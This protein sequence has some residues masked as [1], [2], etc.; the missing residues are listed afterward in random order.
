[1]VNIILC[2]GSGTRLWPLSRSLMP[3]Q[4]LRI[5]D[6]KSLFLLTCERNS[7][8]CEKTIVVSNEQ[9]Y[10]LAL[11]EIS[12]T[13]EIYKNIS[14]LLEPLAKN[15]APAIALACMGLSAEEVV[16]ITPSDHLIKDLLA[17]E[18]VVKKANE[19][20]N[21]GF[22]VTFGIKPTHAETGYG[23]IKSSDNLNV[24][25]FYEK[26]DLKTAQKYLSGGGYFWNSG[27]FMFKA[28]V[29]LEELKKHSND[30]YEM[31]LKAYQNSN[32]NNNTTRIKLDDMTQIPENSID[33]AVMEKSS[34]I[35][36]VPADINWSDLGSFEALSNE[37]KSVEYK[38]VNSNNN[39]V[40]S[41]KLVSLVGVDDLIV[42]DTKDALLISKKGKS[43]NVK[44]I[45]NELKDDEVSKAHTT[46]YRP[47]GSY[48]VLEVANGYK[49]K[50]IVVNVG[51]RLSL[52]KHFHRNEHWIVVSGTASVEI[53]GVKQLV[54]ANESVYIKMGQI[55]RLS[56]DGKIPLVLIE[57]QVGEYTGEDDI[58]RFE[59][60]YNRI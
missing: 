6:N 44:Q 30:I 9:Q 16:L 60:D 53:D 23:Y 29:F 37:I 11:D 4:F 58:V 34:L 42:V 5:F 1:M 51:K 39:F 57:A 17:Y 15:T 56:N 20:A 10:F 46:A 21:E 13:N 12:Q 3:K 22:L 41:D 2:G 47:W 27:M 18:K 48:S 25:G 8:L 55:H 35:K 43:H 49:I 26:P 31:S 36:V 19:L 52:Q 45:V 32:K 14:Y 50:K 40:Y 28:G 33:Y 24:D 38:A 59:D 54:R 7:K